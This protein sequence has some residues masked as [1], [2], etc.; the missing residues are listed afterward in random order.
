MP[1]FSIPLSGRTASSEALSAIANNL[2][3]LNTVGYKDTRVLFRDLFYQS[4]E[5]AAA[6]ILFSWAR[7]LRSVQCRRCSRKAALPRVGRR[8]TL[9]SCRM[10]FYRAEKRNDQLYAGGKFHA[11]SQRIPGDR[12]WRA[13]DGLSGSLQDFVNHF[14][15]Q[16]SSSANR[17]F[18]ASAD[19]RIVRAWQPVAI[20]RFSASA[21]SNFP[22]SA[23]MHHLRRRPCVVHLRCQPC[24][25][26]EWFGTQRIKST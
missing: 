14:P 2:A 7:V 5:P 21:G 12:R 11:G 20:A 8:P 18:C 3:N 13:G 15:Y 1:A 25:W 19:S 10:V 6:E 9:P 26:T 17:M 23:S 24:S 4:L 22:H 16:V